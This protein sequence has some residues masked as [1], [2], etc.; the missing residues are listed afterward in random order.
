MTPYRLLPGAVA[1]LSTMA[2]LKASGVGF[3]AQA[4]YLL[5]LLWA[6]LL[7]G[8][9]VHRATRGRP[10][11]LVADVS[12]GFV[13]G[14][15]LQL[16]AW[17][18]FT[19]AGIPQWQGLW[20]L[21]V[22]F[23]FLAVAGLRRHFSVAPYQHRLHPV[24]A[25]L[26]ITAG[27]VPL[28]GALRGNFI[29]TRLPSAGWIAWAPDT[30]WFMGAAAEL[31]RAVPPQLPQVAGDS[32][33]YHWFAQATN[34]AMSHTTGLD[35][36]VIV[37]RLWLPATL[38]SI[39]G[40]CIALA[41]HLTGKAWIGALAGILITMQATMRFSDGFTLPG[42][43]TMTFLSPSQIYG[44]PVMLLAIVS[45]LDILRS[46]RI[47]A[48]W[49]VA[50]LALIGC[51]G[52]KSS[53]LPVLWCAVL[54]VLMLM[55]LD[56]RGLIGFQSTVRLPGAWQALGAVTVAQLLGLYFIGTAGAGGGLKLFG[57]VTLMRPWR[58]KYGWE[59]YVFFRE[60]MIQLPDGQA[61]LLLALIVVHFLLAGAMILVALPLLRRRV[62]AWLLWGIG[63]AG[64]GGLFLINQDGYSQA[65]FMRGA[66]PAWHVLTAWGVGHLVTEAAR[67]RSWRVALTWCVGGVAAG[68]FLSSALGPIAP[69]TEDS[70]VVVAVGVT[71]L[72]GLACVA[73][74]T[75]LASVGPWLSRVA[76]AGII[77]GFVVQRSFAS[78]IG[79]VDP[80]GSGRWGVWALALCAVGIALI[81]GGAVGRHAVRSWATVSLAAVIVLG[82]ALTAS[83]TTYR[84]SNEPPAGAQT[85]AEI[86]AAQWLNRTAGQFDI[87]ATNL[88]CTRQPTAERCDAR[89]F[90]V[91]GHT[92]RRV[93]V[94]GWGYTA[95]AHARH[96]ENGGISSR[97]VDF[98]DPALFALNE[99]AFY[100]PTEEGIKAM[101]EAGVTWL[102][103]DALA[104]PV[105]E[106]LGDFAQLVHTSGP[107]KIYH[108]G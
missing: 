92:Q 50:T 27:L 64:L 76:A 103:A 75:T 12:L 54:L 21:A 32:F 72:V 81:W 98:H 44:I 104:G 87:V 35:L 49:V 97:H 95:Q 26:S 42:F 86:T 7:P 90:W 102:F 24:A 8:M 52:A 31:K 88:H 36:T 60:P 46:K 71:A 89:S 58:L 15:L 55:L 25:W 34:A 3:R 37:A 48:R 39:V 6:V 85:A 53:V 105:A 82:V 43:E 45:V 4:L 70:D 96:G 33:Q 57:I 93:L 67:R 29:Q 79:S 66:V 1:L 13:T 65:Y 68:A 11:M 16:V 23:A 63:F 22:V 2:I 101:R 56:R 28:L 83:L 41:I 77:L 18:A 78:A 73:V 74:L 62:E 94:E 61:P 59:S 108:I 106:N 107:V 84:P 17:A 38:W 100:A 69:L 80:A 14:L 20:P 47:G 10:T 19:A 5:G 51:A 40:M 9:L 91:S 30:N 99:A